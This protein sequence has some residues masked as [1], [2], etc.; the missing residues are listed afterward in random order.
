MLGS[1]AYAGQHQQRPAPRGG[2]MFKEA[3][4]EEASAKVRFWDAAGTEGGGAYNVG[5]LM[6]VTRDG[7]YYVEDV[8]RGQW[9]TGGEDNQLR[10][11]AETVYSH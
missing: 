7:R 8:V 9:G 10:Q 3:A 2:G 6:S 1:Y 4:S 11:T 5:A